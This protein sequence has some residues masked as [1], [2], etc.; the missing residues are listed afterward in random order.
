MEA[1]LSPIFTT[2]N[3]IKA[4]LKKKFEEQKH[5]E[6]EVELGSVEK[7]GQ[8]EKSLLITLVRVEEETS[9]KQQNAR[10]N[11]NSDGKPFYANPDVC[12]NLYVLIS[13]HAGYGLALQ[14]INDTIYHLNSIYPDD[15]KLSE[16]IRNLSIEL[17]SPNAEQW[18]S[19]WQTLGGKM[20]PSVLYKV[21]MITISAISSDKEA[22]LIEHVFIENTSP[23]RYRNEKGKILNED[24]QKELLLVL[25]KI[26]EEGILHLTLPDLRF[27]FE[28][29]E[30]LDA[31]E[32]KV[33]LSGLREAKEK[34]IILTEKELKLLGNNNI[35]N[36]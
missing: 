13:S 23:L 36:N 1:P 18:N 26:R 33:L 12:L 28:K 6:W 14:Q 32:L 20:V 11:K 21:R 35:N 19:M 3:A 7:D 22:K 25:K 9:V 29:D 10:L 34:G 31:E 24:E 4:Y 5:P 16:D 15:K 27:L 2:L 8:P 17:Q 30:E